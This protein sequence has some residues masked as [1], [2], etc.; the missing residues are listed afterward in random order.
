MFNT[1][2]ILGLPQGA[3]WILIALIALLIFGGRLPQLARNLGKS[4]MEF[5]KGVKESEN[6]I[7]DALNESDKT[8]EKQP[9]EEQ[10]PS[11]G[12]HN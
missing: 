9:P 7:R 12:Y 5:K 10:K 6:E 2:A 1:L 4:I 3:E 11:S 8:A